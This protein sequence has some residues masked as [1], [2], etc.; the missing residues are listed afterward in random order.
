LCSGPRMLGHY[1]IRGTTLQWKSHLLPISG[2]FGF[3]SFY[4]L[5]RRCYS[6][7]KQEKR[8]AYEVLGLHC[9][10]SKKEIKSAYIR[11]SKLY[12]PDRNQADPSQAAQE[13]NQLRE[14]YESLLN[15]P[16]ENSREQRSDSP[17]HWQGERENEY[18]ESED[19]TEYSNYTHS[20][21]FRKKSRSVD[22][23]IKEVERNARIRKQQARYESSKN[24]SSSPGNSGYYYDN[25]KYNY[26]STKD[27]DGGWKFWKPS[28]E[29]EKNY[30]VCETRFLNDIDRLVKHFTIKSLILADVQ[31]N[32]KDRG[33]SKFV[34]FY[35]IFV[36]FLVKTGW[37]ILLS[38]VLFLSVIEMSQEDN[39]D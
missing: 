39:S 16:I 1:L 9:R 19:R 35:L 31:A 37:R 18:R 11:L 8:D 4:C 14:A 5:P 32:F 21:A 26:S 27:S 20:R 22:D 10:A 28:E 15:R 13:F 7:Q 24:K 6:A 2:T 34:L 29:I 33:S 38:V 25:G 12:H 17:D 36:K 3:D 30:S 23:W